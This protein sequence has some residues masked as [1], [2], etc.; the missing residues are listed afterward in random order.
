MVV[1]EGGYRTAT[2]VYGGWFARRPGGI[3]VTEERELY[4]LNGNLQ[5]YPAAVRAILDASRRLHRPVD[6]ITLIDVESTQ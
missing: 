5:K 3:R 2:G 4:Q 6:A 1:K